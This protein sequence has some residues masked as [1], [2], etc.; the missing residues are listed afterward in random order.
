MS[1]LWNFK[2]CYML[3]HWYIFTKMPLG[4]NM[5]PEIHPIALILDLRCLVDQKPR[6]P[7]KTQFFDF[8]E[9]RAFRQA[10]SYNSLEPSLNWSTK[11]I[12]LHF[13]VGAD[14]PGS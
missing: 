12:K 5:C 9:L 11:A 13:Q 14:V 6:N 8:L 7:E 4:L 10:G 1:I 3:E 2:A